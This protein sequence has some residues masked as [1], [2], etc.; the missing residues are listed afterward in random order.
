MNKPMLP[1]GRVDVP[2]L[3]EIRS[4]GTAIVRS[5]HRDVAQ[6]Q[7]G[8]VK[9]TA[10]RNVDLIVATADRVTLHHRRVAVVLQA[11]RL[12]QINETVSFVG[13]FP[14]IRSAGHALN[15]SRVNGAENIDRDFRLSVGL[16]KRWARRV[17]DQ[18]QRCGESEVAVYVDWRAWRDGFSRV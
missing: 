14:K 1:G 4:A 18:F 2:L 15:R 11:V 8:N 16:E 12:P 3:I 10:G 9:I 17:S 13:G 5:G 7:T 6:P